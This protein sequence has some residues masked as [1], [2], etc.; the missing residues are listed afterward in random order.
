VRLFALVV[1]LSSSLAFTQTSP[2]VDIYGGYSYLS[3]DTNGLSDRQSANGW[4]AALSANVWKYLAIEADGAGYYKSISGV[5]I[6]DYSFAGGP[7]FNYRYVFFHS[8]FGVDQLTGSA[9]GLS[10]SQN[11]FVVIEGGGVQIPIAPHSRW[12]IR[13]GADWALTHHNILG[14]PRV[15]QNNFRAG[16]GLVFTLGHRSSPPSSTAQPGQ[17]CG[18]MSP[19]PHPVSLKDLGLEGEANTYGFRIT[20][21]APGSAAAA[22]GLTAGDY[23]VTVNCIK[24]HQPS[25]LANALSRAAGAAVLIINKPTWLPNQTEVHRLQTGGRP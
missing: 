23:I 2:S 21:I 25:E 22:A 14:G 11:S 16:G 1:L 6:T 19:T 3:I 20:A 15:D 7:R 12:S 9:L 5:S 4:E 17:D 24:V 10:A 13:A 8:L 18:T